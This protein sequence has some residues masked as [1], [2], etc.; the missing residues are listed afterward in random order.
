MTQTR[1]TSKSKNQQDKIYYYKHFISSVEFTNF[2]IFDS[3]IS[4][5][6]YFF[7]FPRRREID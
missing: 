5:I 7:S 4:R 3:L 6:N 1:V 2:I